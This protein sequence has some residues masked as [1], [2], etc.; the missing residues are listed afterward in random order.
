MKRHD[1]QSLEGETAP[2]N[3]PVHQTQGKQK[4]T[5]SI[6]AYFQIKRLEVLGMITE[7]KLRTSHFIFNHPMLGL[8]TS[9]AVRL[10]KDVIEES[11]YHCRMSLWIV[12]RYPEHF[13]GKAEEIE[14]D[15]EQRVERV[16]KIYEQF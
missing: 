2:T 12:R 14:K 3:Q 11:L 13:K 7:A 9:Y 4:G 8:F 16:E 1:W 10:S 15:L 5:M 6:K